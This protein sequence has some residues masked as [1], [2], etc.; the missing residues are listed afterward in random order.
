MQVMPLGRATTLSP[1]SLDKYGIPP[2]PP[3]KKQ[4]KYASLSLR[5]PVSLPACLSSSKSHSTLSSL[6][7]RARSPCS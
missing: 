2:N 5:L 4:T 7:D 3:K 1:L 6:P